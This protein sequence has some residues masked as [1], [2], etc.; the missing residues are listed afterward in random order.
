M[1]SGGTVLFKKLNNKIIESIIL[2]IFRHLETTIEMFSLN[3]QNTIVGIFK[4]TIPPELSSRHFMSIG[5][6]IK[7]PN[8]L[9]IKFIGKTF[10]GR[11][12]IMILF[13]CF[14]F[15]N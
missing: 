10:V 4:V 2:Q 7:P 5:D 11:V 3:I 9:I 12:K 6:S 14:L 13:I 8:V 1:T 15:D